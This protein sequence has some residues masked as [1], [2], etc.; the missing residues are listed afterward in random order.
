M[1]KLLV[2]ELDKQ[3]DC[4]RRCPICADD[5]TASYCARTDRYI[6]DIESRPKWCP[7]K[8]ITADSER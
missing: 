3:P 8:E 5:K 1:R 2:I 6:D 4:C 7:I